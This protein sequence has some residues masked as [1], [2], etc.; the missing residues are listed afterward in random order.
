MTFKTCYSVLF[1][2]MFFIT[3]VFSQNI[4][5]SPKLVKS[6][7]TAVG[8]RAVSY[9]YTDLTV[10]I[11]TTKILQKEEAIYRTLDLTNPT[12]NV[13]NTITGTSGAPTVDNQEAILEIMKKVFIKV[14]AN[15]RKLE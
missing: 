7:M 4:T 2:V 11:R 10:T 9:E 6:V 5:P 14:I 1:I 15:R 3:N 8:S 13:T 12:L